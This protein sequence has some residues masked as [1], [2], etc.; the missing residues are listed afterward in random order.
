MKHKKNIISRRAFINRAGLASFGLTTASSSLFKLHSLKAALSQSNASSFED[1]KALVC[2]FQTGGND[3]YNMLVPRGTSE[4]AEYASVRT[5]L[6]LDQEDLLPISP[7]NPDG[8]EYGLHPSLQGVQELFNA[9]K[10]AFINNVGTLIQPV[11]KAEFDDKS[12]P[13]P[14]GLFSHSDQIAQW[15]TGQPHVRVNTGWGGKLAEMFH[16]QNLNNDISMNITLSGTNIFQFGENIVQYSVG[17]SGDGYGIKGYQGSHDFDEART[18]LIDGM[19]NASYTDIYKQTYVDVI[20]NSI[21]AQT[22]FRESIESLPEFQTDFSGNGLSRSFEMI[23]KIIRA[24]EILGFKRQIFF[25][26]IGGWDHH[27]GLLQKQD[28]MLEVVGNAMAQFS[29]AL[30]EID[31]FQEVVTFSMS[32]FAR[33]LTSNGDGSDHAWGGNVMVMGGPVKGNQMY[34]QYPDLGLDN[35][36]DIGRG[37]LIP[38]LSNDEYFAELALWFGVP[39]SDLPLIFPNIGNFYNTSGTNLPIGYLNM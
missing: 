38:T 30:E 5:N 19:L 8:K 36:L 4:Y 17:A 14:L 24:R 11:S 9:G 32:E 39:P 20:K 29:A 18:V 2:L 26:R 1:Y 34:G 37:R 27:D 13:L 33:T 16:T 3:S 35:Q 15:Q 25:V 7:A 21:E 23:A 12:V 10:L 28:G 31:A 6:A 22:L